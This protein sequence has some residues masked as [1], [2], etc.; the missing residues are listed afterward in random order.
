[1]TSSSSSPSSVFA[2]PPPS[3]WPYSDCDKI[4]PVGRV[5][6]T[7]PD[8]KEVP[9]LFQPLTIRG[10]TFKN[11]IFVSPM[12]TYSSPDGFLT[13]W[14]VVHQGQF[15][16]GGAA[17]VVTEATAVQFNGRI[18]PTDAG[19]WKD[20]QIESYKRVVDFLH[21]NNT[22]AGIQ[23]GHAGRKAST[24]PPYFPRI[25]HGV[26]DESE[27]GWPDQVQGP[28]P[29]PW[30]DHWI[31]PKE[32]TVEQIQELIQ[33]FVAAT[34]RAQKAGYDVVEIHGAHGYMI[35]SFL[36]SLTNQRTDQYGG[37]FENRIR[38]CLEVC[39][40]VRAVW[41]AEKPLFLRI[42]C[43]D[44][45]EGGWDLEQT[46]QLAERLSPVGIDLLD[47]SGGGNVPQQ[48]FLPSTFEGEVVSP[49]V[50]L[51]PGYQTHFSEAV[52][53]KYGPSLFTGAVG[54]ISTGTQ[55]E[56]ILTKN[57][58]DAIFIGREYLR[59]PRFAFTA[60]KELGVKLDWVPQYSWIPK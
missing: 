54:L 47:C 24:R 28:S 7:I 13:D 51:I 60:A 11:R 42:S 9:L 52:K 1:M 48:K 30:S 20:E 41:P 59:D 25:K 40:A 27:G 34:I 55:A 23:L 36:S 15:A 29:L 21:A 32:L 16:I 18:S 57:K 43:S 53:A 14:H 5:A 33:D 4:A 39:T 12:C 22:M 17:L 31:M 2:P 46:L 35:S 45:A 49:A 26:A 56:E 58:A 3:P 37:S 8:D 6:G 38:L 50:K 19:L 44:F 10:V